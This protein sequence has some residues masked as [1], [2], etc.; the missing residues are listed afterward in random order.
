M[1]KLISSI[2]LLAFLVT[3]FLTAGPLTALSQES[4]ESA[5]VVTEPPTHSGGTNVIDFASHT[6]GE[7]VLT[8]DL[9]NNGTIYA[10]STDPNITSAIFTAPNIFNNAGA[11]ITTVLPS[12][13][14]SGYANA[15]SGLNL[16]FKAA[17]NF[18]NA[19]AIYSAGSLNITAGGTITN[20]LPPNVVAAAPVMQAVNNISLTSQIGN[21][22]NAGTIASMSGNINLSSVMGNTLNINNMN[23]VLQALN[24]SIDIRDSLYTGSS[25]LTMLGGDW[26]SESLNIMNDQGAING[27]L[28]RVTGVV[29]GI[30]NGAQFGVLN[31]DLNFGTWK[32]DGDPTYYSAQGSIT[33]VDVTTGGADI[34]FIAHQDI[35]GSTI[36]IDTTS[37][38]VNAG[39]IL[40]VAGAN[41]IA[42]TSGDGLPDGLNTLVTFTAPSGSDPGGSITADQLTLN[43]SGSGPFTNGGNITVVAFQGTTANSGMINVGLASSFNAGIAPGA[44]ALGGDVTI[45]AGGSDGTDSLIIGDV[46]SS[47]ATN[48]QSI[49]I[50]AATP[51]ITAPGTISVLNGTA[52][53][54]SGTFEPGALIDGNV[55]TGNIAIDGFAGPPNIGF[56]A[57]GAGGNG[58]TIQMGTLGSMFTG[59]ISA[60]GG[61]GGSGP[62]NLAGSGGNGGTVTITGNACCLGNIDVSGGDGGTGGTVASIQLP[63]GDGG[64]G[65]TINL[66]SG[67]EMSSADLI[68]NGGRGG[69]GIF[70]GIPGA[71][72][73]INV[74]AQG[75]VF[76]G[77][78]LAQAG[79]YG[80][81]GPNMGANGGSITVNSVGTVVG[82]F[83]DISVIGSGTILNRAGSINIS[84]FDQ[85]GISG[86][87]T[88]DGT[89]NAN[90]GII[91]LTSTSTT[92]GVAMLG[93][94]GLSATNESSGTGGIVTVTAPVVLIGNTFTGPS[95]DVSS[96]GGN[97]AG[98]T[99]NLTT[100]SIIPL[101]TGCS[102]NGIAGDLTANGPRSGGR[103]N[104]NATGGFAFTMPINVTASASNPSGNGG[105]IQ[106]TSPG[107]NTL[108]VINEGNIEAVGPGGGGRI[109]F[110]SGPIGNVVV[111][112]LGSLTATDFVS[113][114]ELDPVTLDPVRPMIFG[115]MPVFNIGPAN[116]SQFF[117]GNQIRISGTLPPRPPTPAPP[118]VIATLTPLATPLPPVKLP[119]PLPNSTILSTDQTPFSTPIKGTTETTHDPLLGTI[120]GILFSSSAS[121][122]SA[123]GIKI[124]ALNG[125]DTFV[126]N[127]GNLLIKPAAELVNGI[128][129]KTNEGTLHVAQGA[130]AFL[131]ETGHDVAVYALHEPFKGSISFTSGSH[132][133]DLTTGQ[134][135][136]FTRNHAAEFGSVNPGA[137][138]PARNMESHVLDNGVKAFVGEFSMPAALAIIQPLREM[139]ASSDATMRKTAWAV[140]KNAAI[141]SLIGTRNGPYKK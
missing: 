21:I 112:G 116:V 28:N 71:G 94:G 60:R 90:G 55:I 59:D 114:G 98:G 53:M 56:P 136:V 49:R 120:N 83:G 87:V 82:V 73:S 23:G 128:S 121:L 50:F 85:I 97:G 108:S 44:I 129:I 89:I 130:I 139:R 110:N 95:I 72:G 138:I 41:F 36:T 91:T 102:C 61:A 68:A 76:V 125:N 84:A 69:D 34:A 77:N 2:S 22:V 24:G 74:Q 39:S 54:G 15:I 35:T 66:S 19:G 17:N 42:P 43:A 45:I 57:A 100:T 58:G 3:L 33:L 133:I 96:L 8:T 40:L 80:A 111:T 117:V 6:N 14:L 51:V 38:G 115:P 88:A 4:G 140:E 1:N 109:G 124:E 122:Q 78:L 32:I 70:S 99:I 79:A 81:G 29:N 104:L 132:R 75:D 113:F 46:T 67:G 62:Q 106:F 26:L 25:A 134:Q 37:G 92:G 13:G 52:Q 119:E 137:F 65:G 105:F 5:A 135:A 123:S 12:G 93:G 11:T 118:L 30:G 18:V 86:Q 20:A 101:E 16:V 126:L 103:I 10:V 127:Q 64:S 27:H 47:A 141:L 9:V 31:G 7:L 48:Q 107:S 63:G 131:M